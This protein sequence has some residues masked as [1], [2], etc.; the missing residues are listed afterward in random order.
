MS[1]KLYYAPGAWSFIP[2]VLPVFLVVLLALVQLDQGGLEI[3]AA[4]LQQHMRDE[5]TGARGVIGLC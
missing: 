5:G 3:R 1:M 4:H 2:H